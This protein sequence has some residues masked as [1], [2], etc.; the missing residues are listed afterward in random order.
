MMWRLSVWTNRATIAHNSFNEILFWYSSLPQR[1]WTSRILPSFGKLR[2]L[3]FYAVLATCFNCS[4]RVYELCFFH[5]SIILFGLLMWRISHF[6]IS[7]VGLVISH[8][9]IFFAL[10]FICNTKGVLNEVY[11]KWL[12]CFATYAV[13][14]TCVAMDT[15]KLLSNKLWD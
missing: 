13:H 2:V 5:L 6:D 8:F 7:F 12:F 4:C 15:P 14:V 9:D 3:S 11:C 1:W 10:L